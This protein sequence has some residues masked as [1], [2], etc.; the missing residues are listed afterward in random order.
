MTGFLWSVMVYL[1]LSVAWL[2][3][4]KPA[5]TIAW[6]ERRIR[7]LLLVRCS[8]LGWALYLLWSAR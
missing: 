5:Q 4:L 8:L 7:A 3:L 6:S 2:L 1:V